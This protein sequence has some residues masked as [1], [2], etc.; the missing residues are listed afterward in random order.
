MRCIR[1]RKLIWNDVMITVWDHALLDICHCINQYT[2]LVSPCLSLS[3]RHT[4]TH[5]HTHEFDSCLSNTAAKLLKL[6]IGSS[7][8]L[9]Q[10]RRC[11]L[12]WK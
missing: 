12:F 7:F 5:I 8:T 11:S 2:L 6:L 9:T 3:F 1:N 4:H 10:G